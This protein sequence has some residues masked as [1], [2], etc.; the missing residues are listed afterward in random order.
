MATIS[1]TVPDAVV[2]RLLDAFCARHGYTGT[3][4]NGNPQTKAQFIN[5]RTKQW[6]RDEALEHER[7]T[8]AAAART[9]NPDIVL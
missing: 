6:W 7:A 9:N 8:A 5:M 2:P 3:D 1:I 4:E